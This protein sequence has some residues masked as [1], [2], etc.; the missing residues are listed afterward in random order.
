MEGFL[1]GRL[2]LMI[3]LLG[4]MVWFLRMDMARIWGFL[5]SGNYSWP[6]RMVHL[7]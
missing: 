7:A 6:R 2:H 1:L 4:C 3:A 5:S